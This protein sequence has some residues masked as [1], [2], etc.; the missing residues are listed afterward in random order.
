MTAIFRT[1]SSHCRTISSSSF[2]CSLQQTTKCRHKSTAQV[3]VLAKQK[4]GKALTLLQGKSKDNMENEMFE[5]HMFKIIEKCHRDKVLFLGCDISSR[6][7]GYGLLGADGKGI[8]CGGIKTDTSPDVIDICNEIEEFLN[9]EI[10][11]IIWTN[12]YKGYELNIIFEDCMTS[13]SP[14]RFNA[15]GLM[16]LAQV[17][18]IAR[19]ATEKSFGIRPQLI[20]P[21]GAR[22]F[23]QLLRAKKG[24]KTVIKKRVYNYVTEYAPHLPWLDNGKDLAYDMTDGYLVAMYARAMYF[25]HAILADKLLWE[26]VDVHPSILDNNIRAAYGKVAIDILDKNVQEWLKK[27]RGVIGLGLKEEEE[28]EAEEGIGDNVVNM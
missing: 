6:V 1:I 4:L 17:N 27:R 8:D 2:K 22:G 28:E 13:Y 5:E 7:T 21:S 18:G 19:F 25:K 15:R 9:N 11:P 3:N 23:F 10:K 12:K 16:K 14:G 26:S 24:D 20:H